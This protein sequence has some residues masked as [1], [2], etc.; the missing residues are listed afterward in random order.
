MYL[1]ATP[2]DARETMYPQFADDL[3]I[4]MVTSPHAELRDQDRAVALATKIC[5]LTDY[6]DEA[7]VSALAT[8]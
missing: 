7:A 5:E 8:V 1:H 4:Y 2:D 6:Q 3:A